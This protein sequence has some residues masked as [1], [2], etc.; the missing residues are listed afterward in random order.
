MKIELVKEQDFGDTPWYSIHID[1]A[2]ISGS[3]TRSLKDAEGFYDRLAK[4]KDYMKKTKEILKS[5]EI[6]VS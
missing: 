2:Y 5:Q 3:M 6:V 1:N 4:D